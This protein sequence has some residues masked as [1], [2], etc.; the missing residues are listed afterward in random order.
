MHACIHGSW[1]PESRYTYTAVQY[2]SHAYTVQYRT[3]RL[4]YVKEGV[5]LVGLALQHGLSRS[6][7]Y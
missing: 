6:N 3:T 4:Y 5:A 2:R 1:F 7:S